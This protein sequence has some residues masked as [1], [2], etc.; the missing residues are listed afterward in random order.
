MQVKFQYISMHFLLLAQ[1]DWGYKTRDL[2]LWN[3]RSMHN[4]DNNGVLTSFYYEFHFELVA[5]S[6]SPARGT[7]GASSVFFPRAI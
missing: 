6:L 2:V 5:R 4:Y 1:R 3:Q 7:R